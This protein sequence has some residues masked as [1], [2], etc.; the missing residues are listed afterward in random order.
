MNLR[1]RPPRPVAARVAP[2]YPRALVVATAL[3]ASSCAIYPLD[4]APQSP[5]PAGDIAI[6]YDSGP[7]RVDAKPETE[8]DG[9]LPEVGPDGFTI[10]PYEDGG[11]DTGAP[12]SDAAAETLPEPAGDIAYPF[13]DAGPPPSDAAPAETSA[14]ETTP[15]PAGDIAYPYEDGGEDGGSSGD[16]G[17][18]G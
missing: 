3:L 12:P 5:D 2:S 15:D 6:P 14:A 7:D 9:A 11:A 16:A 10:S 17:A 4:D 8:G 13:E 18:G 1:S